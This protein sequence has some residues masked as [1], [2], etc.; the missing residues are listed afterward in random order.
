LQAEYRR[1]VDALERERLREKR[2]QYAI[3]T[4]LVVAVI[5]AFVVLVFVMISSN[6]H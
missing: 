4:I 5:A 2:V 1:K 6:K 3:G